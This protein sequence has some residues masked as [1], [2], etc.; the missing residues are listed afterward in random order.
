M[1][2]LAAPVPSQ[3]D[4]EPRERL[5][6]ASRRLRPALPVLLIGAVLALVPTSTCIARLLFGI[7]CPACGLT[8]ATLAAAHLDFAAALRYHP[9][10]LALMAAT[11]AMM[12]LAF[13]LSDGAWRR[14][15][16]IVTGGAGVALVI[17]WA[18]RFVGLF[19]G[20]VPG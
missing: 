5:R 3:H 11:A 1:G 6:R 12:A 2:P 18:L 10:S 15:V 19:G 20:P 13:V 16:A 4:M 17:V 8:R 7:P 14:A 9:L